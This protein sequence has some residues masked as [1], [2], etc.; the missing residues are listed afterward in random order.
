M[1]AMV[2]MWYSNGL[3]IWSAV[4][5]HGALC[6]KNGRVHPIQHCGRYN[7]AAA[8]L[9]CSSPCC[10]LCTCVEYAEVFI[11]FFNACGITAVLPRINNAFATI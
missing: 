3:D 9:P 4:S 7:F 2:A 8:Q 5:V 10:H 11:I 1:P 6:I